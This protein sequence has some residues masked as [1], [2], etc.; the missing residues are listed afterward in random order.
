MKKILIFLIIFIGIFMVNPSFATTTVKLIPNST[1][2]A[3]TNA[4]YDNNCN[5]YATFQPSTEFTDAQY[6]QV[7]VSENTR[8]SLSSVYTGASSRCRYYRFTFNLTAAG[9]NINQVSQLLFL[10][11]GLYTCTSCVD[12]SADLFT[13]NTSYSSWDWW[14]VLNLASDTTITKTVTSGIANYY[15]ASTGLI[16]IGVAMAGEVTDKKTVTGYTDL[17]YLNVTYTVGDSTPP[18][19]SN[20]SINTTCAG[21]PVNIST[22]I[23]DETALSG[24]IFS[25]NNTGTWVNTTWVS[26]TSGQLATNRTTLNSTITIVNYTWYANDTSNNWATLRNRTT[27]TDCTQPTYAN[28]STNSTTAGTPVLHSLNWTDNVLLNGYIFS[29]NNGTSTTLQFLPNSTATNKAYISG[30]QTSGAVAACM[31]AATTEFS[32]DAYNQTNTSNNIYNSTAVSTSGTS[33][34]YKCVKYTFNLSAIPLSTMNSI[35]YCYEGYNATA[36]SAGTVVLYY[37][38]NDTATWTLDSTLTATDTTYCTSF[39]TIG[40]IYNSTSGLVSI[41]VQLNAPYVGGA[42]TTTSYTDFANVTLT[43]QNLSNASWVSMTGATNWSNVTKVV[44]STVGTNIFW[45][46]YANDTGNNWNG[47]SCANP[48]NYLTT[49]AG[50]DTC[51]YSGSGNW[52]IDCKDNCTISSSTTVTGNIS[53]YSTGAG[54]LLF[55]NNVFA[56]GFYFNATNTCYWYYNNYRWLY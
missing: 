3:Y 44:N 18:T 13:F 40:N 24:Y 12:S 22:T 39:T 51:T 54:S 38:K 56:N 50:G 28:N 8:Y 27:T 11:E 20:P 52:F 32:D 30:T 6:S 47:T 45:C 1:S 55:S 53:L 10:H 46:V 21:K 14:T 48:F 25:T 19:F 31:D 2:K 42:E 16:Q 15:Q 34:R 9:I 23:S 36:S 5:E 4:T 7:N 33:S 49:S 17:V 43:Y 41:G 29:F 37:Y 26:L 35:R